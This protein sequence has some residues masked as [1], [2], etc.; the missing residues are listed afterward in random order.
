MDKK[1]VIRKVIEYSKEVKK[2]LN[3]KKVI[4]FGSYAYG[5]PTEDSD[6]DIAF[7]VDRLSKDTDYLTLMARLNK[8]ARSID[9]RIEPHIFE[10]INNKSGFLDFISKK[11]DEIK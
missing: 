5:N 7:I 2:Y 1:E 9:S 3:Y 6:I 8:I 10:M 4:L 11:G